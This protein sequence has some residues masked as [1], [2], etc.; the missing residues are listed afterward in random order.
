MHSSVQADDIPQANSSSLLEE[1]RKAHTGLLEAIDE[2]RVLTLGPMPAKAK[3]VDTRWKVSSASLTRRL[4]WGRILMSVSGRLGPDDQ[5]ELRRLQDMDIELLRTSI[6][7]VGT[8]TG[9]AILRDWET[10]CRASESMRSRMKAAIISERQVLYP[11]LMKVD[12]RAR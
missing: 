5:T 2:L 6:K 8:W 7:H 1:L 4:L 10:Y 12:R 3:L 9:E 11:I